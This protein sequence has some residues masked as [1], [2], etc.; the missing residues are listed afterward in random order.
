LANVPLF[1]TA[2]PNRSAVRCSFSKDIVKAQ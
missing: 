1:D 2:A